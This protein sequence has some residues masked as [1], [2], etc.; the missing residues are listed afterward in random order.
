MAHDPCGT[1]PKVNATGAAGTRAP[2]RRAITFSVAALGLACVALYSGTARFAFVHWD[3]FAELV[4]NPAL[5]GG[6]SLEAF[7][8]AFRFGG[9]GLFQ[10]LSWLSHALDFTLFGTDPAGPH[11]VNTALHATNAMLLLLLLRR[12]TGELVPSLLSAALWALHPLR[13]EPVAWVSGRKDL[14][15]FTLAL[16]TVAAYGAFAAKPTPRRRLTVAALF[17]LALLAKPVVAVLPLALLAVDFWPLGRTAGTPF[18]DLLREKALLLALAALALVPTILTRLQ[19]GAIRPV[20]EISIPLRLTNAGAGFLWYVENAFLPRDLAF[21]YPLV[22]Q[23]SG[24]L[25]AAGLLL[26]LGGTG[27]AVLLSKRSPALLAGWTWFV[28]LLAPTIGFV[29]TGGQ[30]AADRYSYLP[31]AGLTAGI[32]FTVDALLRGRR[33]LPKAR[34]AAAF[35][36][37][38]LAAAFAL[39][40][41]A[42]TATWRNDLALF[43]NAVEVTE[44]NWLAHYNLAT[45]LE[46]HGDFE[47]ALRQALATLDIAPAWEPGLRLLTGLLDRLDRGAELLPHALRAVRASPGSSFAHVLA[48]DAFRARG[49]LR[50]ARTFYEKALA[51]PPV[52][53]GA[54]ER[55]ASLD[56]VGAAQPLSA[57]PASAGTR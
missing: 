50:A 25:I 18:R 3:D 46:A 37:A 22:F 17:C 9:G 30:R 16:A 38:A 55:L 11:M 24:R 29:Q 12:A 44:G 27:V 10:P 28:V 31:A 43:G 51:L 48:G 13:V 40:S 57:R 19:A 6:I 54:R 8:W 45:T 42:Q 1:L 35:G 23:P 7:R 36:G 47:G 56:A 32:V 20:S 4:D 26:F 14:L 15:A 2:S 41:Y 33:T 52:D 21:Y 53:P 34:T 39:S 5:R 49:D